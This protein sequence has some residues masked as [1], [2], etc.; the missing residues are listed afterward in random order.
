MVQTLS[1]YTA[2]RIPHCP[3]CWKWIT[4]SDPWTLSKLPAD[5][6]KPPHDSVQEV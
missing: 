5:R 6:L 4:S 2:M 1:I 3:S